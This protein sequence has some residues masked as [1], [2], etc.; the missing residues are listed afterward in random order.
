MG[1]PAPSHACG[2]TTVTVAPACRD[3]LR[4][5]RTCPSPGT[6]T[7]TSRVAKAWGTTLDGTLS[8]HSN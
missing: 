2:A 4:L 8:R 1:A 5:M 3:T 7:V 6:S